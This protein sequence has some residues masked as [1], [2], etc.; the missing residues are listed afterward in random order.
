M[1]MKKYRKPLLDI[2]EFD[3]VD[4]VTMSNDDSL[5]GNTVPLEK[6]DEEQ[7]T[8]SSDSHE[9]GDFVQNHL[10]SVEPPSPEATPEPD[11]SL[12]ESTVHE[13]DT[14]GTEQEAEDSTEPDVSTGPEPTEDPVDSIPETDAYE[15]YAVEEYTDDSSAAE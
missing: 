15:E 12:E 3:N 8:I 1:N 5:A 7:P 6:V 14:T 4:V 13:E 2:V 11:T 9:T 10:D